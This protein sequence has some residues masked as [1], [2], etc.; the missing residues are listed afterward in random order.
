ML[1]KSAARIDGAILIRLAMSATFPAAFTTTR[2]GRRRRLVVNLLVGFLVVE[3][4]AGEILDVGRQLVFEEPAGGFDLLLYPSACRPSRHITPVDRGLQ[5]DREDGGV[6][7][8]GELA[9]LVN[10]KLRKVLAL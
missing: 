9:V 4:E 10:C 3:R 5:V 6:E 7:Q 1:A 8:I 2:R